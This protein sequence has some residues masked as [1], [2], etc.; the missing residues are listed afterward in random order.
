MKRSDLMK[1]KKD[2]EEL[3]QLLDIVVCALAGTHNRINHLE[4]KLVR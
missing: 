4:R 1:I 3:K 2:V